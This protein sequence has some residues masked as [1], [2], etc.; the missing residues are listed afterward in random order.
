MLSSSAVQH[1]GIGCS[2]SA[3]VRYQRREPEVTLLHRI[4]CGHLATFLVEAQERYPSGELPRFIRAEFE[5]YLRCA[6]FFVETTLRSA[7]RNPKAALL[8]LPG[9]PK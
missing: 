3:V 2:V 9:F 7:T 6:L 8:G 4:V 1:L 5:R